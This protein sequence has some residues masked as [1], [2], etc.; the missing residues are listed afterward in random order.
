MRKYDKYT[1]FLDVKTHK[2]YYSSKL[3]HL[4]NIYATKCMTFVYII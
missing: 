3:T 4:H 2:V 1:T